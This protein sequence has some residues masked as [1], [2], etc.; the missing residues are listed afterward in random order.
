MAAISALPNGAAYRCNNLYSLVGRSRLPVYIV[1]YYI[2]L[3]HY[4]VSKAKVTDA[5][6][7]SGSSVDYTYDI[8]NITWSFGVEL[9]DLGQYGFELPETEI[10]PTAEESFQALYTIATHV[11]ASRRN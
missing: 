6:Q 7:S 3:K 1:W 2:I 9:R 10:Q 4:T 5:G 11:I 8:L